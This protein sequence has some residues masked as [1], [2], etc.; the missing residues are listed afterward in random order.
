MRFRLLLLLLV[1]LSALAACSD[2]EGNQPPVVTIVYP[3]PGQRFTV[4]PDS[5]LVLSLIHI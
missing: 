2:D 5:I 1:A 3:D 4:S